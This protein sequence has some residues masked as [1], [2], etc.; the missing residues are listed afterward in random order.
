MTAERSPMKRLSGRYGAIAIALLV[1][2]PSTSLPAEPERR[3]VAYYFHTTIRC[4]TCLL[5]EERAG[6]VLGDA[7]AGQIA[8]GL[9]KWQPVNVQA[10]ENRHYLTKLQ[11]RPKSLTLIEYYDDVATEKKEL[12]GVWRLV[13]GEPEEFRQYLAEEVGQFLNSPEKH[14]EATEKQP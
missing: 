12:P 10:A 13:H 4:N 6:Q 2:L 3:V 11:V 9:L 1:L 8:D 5:I 7:F 14:T